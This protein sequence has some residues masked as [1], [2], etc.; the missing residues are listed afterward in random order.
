MLTQGTT[1]RSITIA[2]CDAFLR[3]CHG[4]SDDINRAETFPSNESHHKS[5]W[6]WR[7]V[8]Y[9]CI[10]NFFIF[11]QLASYGL[12]M[13]T[14]TKSTLYMKSIFTG[15]GSRAFL[16]SSGP[17]WSIFIVALHDNVHVAAAVVLFVSGFFKETLY[18]GNVTRTRRMCQRCWYQQLTI[19]GLKNECHGK[20]LCLISK[21]FLEYAWIS[22]QFW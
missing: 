20:Q 6:F 3:E 11:I 12:D 19:D 10:Y 1:L 16:E 2:F 5:T 17:L 21:L 14:F 9:C 7:S 8:Q 22:S 4:S 13:T 15:H 18:D